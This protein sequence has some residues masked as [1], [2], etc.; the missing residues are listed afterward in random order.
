MTRRKKKQI[1]IAFVYLLFW[2]GVGFFVYTLYIKPAPSCLDGIQNQNEEGIDCGGSCAKQC[3]LVGVLE[4]NLLFVE[5]VTLPGERS[6]VVA[7]LENPNFEYGASQVNYRVD[8]SVGAGGIVSK[9][10]SAYL[11]PRERKYVI[12][13]NL[14]YPAGSFVGFFLEEITWTKLPEWK[15]NNVILSVKDKNYRKLTG[16][17]AKSEAVGVVVN[18]SDFDFD[19]VDVNIVLFGKDSRVIGAV[20]HE[21]RTLISSEER[22]FRVIWP[23]DLAEAGRFDMEAET[24]FFSSQNFMKRYGEPGKFKELEKGDEFF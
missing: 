1:I 13:N 22:N 18:R 19:K 21:I 6:G 15:T 10:D 4:P 7:R 2:M 24:D 16:E 14:P 5:A 12:E 20:K 17:A 23:F 9:R 11:L 8:F 3:P